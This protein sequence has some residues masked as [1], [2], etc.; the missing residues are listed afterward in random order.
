MYFVASIFGVDSQIRLKRK[1]VEKVT[2]F[3][4]IS[5]DNVQIVEDFSNIQYY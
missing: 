1:N 5:D 4:R 3:P 2:W